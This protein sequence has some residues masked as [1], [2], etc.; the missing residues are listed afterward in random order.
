[1]SQS[2]STLLVSYVPHKKKPYSRLASNSNFYPFL[3]AF[4]ALNAV[5][6]VLV[7][8][9]QSNYKIKGDYDS[10]LPQ[11]ELFGLTISDNILINYILSS[12]S[13]LLCGWFGSF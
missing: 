4:A 6:S 2:S 5:S 12:V 9:W 8:S 3:L 11:E 1:M 10:L 7:V 13:P